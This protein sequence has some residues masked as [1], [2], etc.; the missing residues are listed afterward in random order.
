MSLPNIDEKQETNTKKLS[1]FKI[2]LGICCMTKKMESSRTINVLSRIEAFGDI[3]IIKIDDDIL[4]NDN[5][6]VYEWPKCDIF[7]CFFSKG[8]PIDKVLLYIK[9]NPNIR[10]IN[11]LES[12]KWLL[13]RVSVKNILIKNNIPTPKY[14]ILN[15]ESNNYNIIEYDNKIIL[16]GVTLYKPFFE[17]PIDAENHNIYLY[18]KNGGSRRLFRK[19][20]DRSSE[21]YPYNNCIRSQ[22]NYIYE[23]CIPSKRGIIYINIVS[24]FPDIYLIY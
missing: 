14:G 15:R 7:I 16:N 6:S 21:A 3:E 19:I 18:Y 17:K 8:Y 22:G 9:I 20:K 11:D 4:F 12:Q 2:K 5:I 24:I 13:N 1:Y 23:A 10:L